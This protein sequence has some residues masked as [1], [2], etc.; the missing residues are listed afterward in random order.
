[1]C[2]LYAAV[3]QYTT[4]YN[5]TTCKNKQRL[6]NSHFRNWDEGEYELMHI[7]NK[8]ITELAFDYNVFTFVGCGH[9]ND[10]N[11]LVEEE[12]FEYD[13]VNRYEEDLLHDEDQKRRRSQRSV[14]GI[15]DE[16]LAKSY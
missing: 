9:K 1:M 8:D 4:S 10:I 6:G 5:I 16:V 12:N 13:D 11:D 15:S 14:E 7:A 3:Y 2:L